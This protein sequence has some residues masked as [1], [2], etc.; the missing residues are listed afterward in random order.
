MLSIVVG[1]VC[2]VLDFIFFVFV[3]GSNEVDLRLEIIFKVDFLYFVI[4]LVLFLIIV[5]VVISLFI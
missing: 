4:F 2:M 3:C 1:F 5:M